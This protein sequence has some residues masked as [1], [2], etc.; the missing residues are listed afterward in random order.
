ML[1]HITYDNPPPI[2]STDKELSQFSKK[3]KPETKHEH[4]QSTPIYNGNLFLLSLTF[5]NLIEEAPIIKYFWKN[6]LQIPLIELPDVINNDL[7]W[8]T[9]HYVTCQTGLFSITG[10][11]QWQTCLP[12]TVPYT[13]RLLTYN[14]LAE[15]KQSELLNS[16]DRYIKNSQDFVEKCWF[17]ISMQTALGLSYTTPLLPAGLGGLNCYYLHN[18]ESIDDLSGQETIIPYI[19]SIYAGYLTISSLRFDFN[20]ETEILLSIDGTFTT[21]RSMV[22]VHDITTLLLLTTQEL[23]APAYDFIINTVGDLY[24]YYFNNGENYE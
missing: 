7:F 2:Y 20:T 14:F 10:Q 3:T 9:T 21:I 13:M 16:E 19:T 11:T 22:V 12:A 15:Q 17:D 23:R 18:Q 8:I 4:H 5:K 1:H 6:M 24:D